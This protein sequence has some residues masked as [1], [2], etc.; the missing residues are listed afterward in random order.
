MFLLV[1]RNFLKDLSRKYKGL[2]LQLRYFN[3]I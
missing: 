1:Y 3:V 2:G